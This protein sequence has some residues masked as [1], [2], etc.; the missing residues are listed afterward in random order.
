[1]FR[2]SEPIELVPGKA[3]LPKGAAQGADGDGIMPRNSRGDES[4]RRAFAEL[5]VAPLLSDDLETR[6]EE[7]TA[8]FAER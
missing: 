5:H 1:V 7:P 8:D 2:R 6:G 4:N 3:G